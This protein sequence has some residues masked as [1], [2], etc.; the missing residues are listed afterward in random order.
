AFHYSCV[1][2]TRGLPVPCCLSL[3]YPS[4]FKVVELDRKDALFPALFQHRVN[5]VLIDALD[6][7]G[8]HLQG[9]PATFFRNVEPFDLQ[10]RV[11]T[12]LRLVVGVRYVVA[13]LGPFSRYLTD[14]CHSFLFFPLLE[15]GLQISLKPP[16]LS[17][18]RGKLSL[19][20]EFSEELPGF[21][22]LKVVNNPVDGGKFIFR[23]RGRDPNYPASGRL[24]G[25]DAGNGVLEDNTL[26]GRQIQGFCRFEVNLGVRLSPGHERFVQDDVEVRLSAGLFQGKV[27]VFTRCRGCDRA[28]YPKG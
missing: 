10:V 22:A 19:R 21:Q 6:R 4:F 15:K 1:P 9:D 23:M 5:T 13:N 12:P 16:Q 8:G 24:G 25:E 11:K 28:R 20:L 17:N 26:G 7:L 18:H 2:C 14:S 3:P 27:N